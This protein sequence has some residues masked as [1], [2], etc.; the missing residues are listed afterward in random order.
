MFCLPI[1]LRESLNTDS[2][3][4]LHELEDEVLD[5]ILKL[6]VAELDSYIYA[7]IC[8]FYTNTE[9]GSDSYKSLY[10]SYKASFV[11]E[12]LYRV[13]SVLAE[14]YTAIYTK[15]GLIREIVL[16]LYSIRTEQLAI[17]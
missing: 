17:H 1:F 4:Y 15:T 6:P 13:N 2:F 5:H 10:E 3:F 14:Q 12:K 16:D 11:L 9:V 8:R 7:L